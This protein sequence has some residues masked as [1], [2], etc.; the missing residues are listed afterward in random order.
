MSQGSL[1]EAVLTLRA[2]DR[3]LAQ[4]LDNAHRKTAGII[5]GLANVIQTGLGTALGIG[6]A[7]LTQSIVGIGTSIARTGLDF[8]SM[9]QQS[10]I[11][12]TTMLG[13]GEKARSFLDNLQQ[14]AAST[15]FEFPDLV[16]ASQKLVSVGVDASRVIPIMTA[17]GDATAAMGTGGEGIKRATLAM[18]QMAQ[19][20]KVTGEEMLQ[21]VEAGIP[22]WDALASKLGV[23]VSKA[24]DMVSKKQVKFNDLL[25]ALESRSGKAMQRVKGMMD[26]QSRSFSGLLSTL[27]DT[28]AQASG[29][30]MQPFFDLLTKTFQTIVDFTGTED[31]QRWVD[32]AADGV[33][34]FIDTGLLPFLT[35]TWRVLD[36]DVI[37]TLRSVF[38]IVGVLATGD[39]DGGIFGLEEDDPWLTA[40][41]ETRFAL[42]E[43]VNWV[44]RVL[45][46]IQ[47][48][49][50]GLVWQTLISGIQTAW[51]T[52][53]PV[54]A[55]WGSKFWDW[56]TVV[57]LP[58][59]GGKL[60][61]V[62]AGIVGWVKDNGPAKWQELTNWANDFWKWLTGPEGAIQ[63]AEAEVQ[64]VATRLATVLKD[65]WEN[66][67][68]PAFKVWSDGFW[69][70]LDGEDGVIK[71]A[72][73]ELETLTAAIKEWANSA[74][75]QTLVGEL[76]RAIGIGIVEGI[77][78]SFSNTENTDN[79][80]L[81]LLRSFNTSIRN[82]IDSIWALGTT[83]VRGI[84][85]GVIKDAS[86]SDA[87]AIVGGGVY[88][89]ISNA[90]KWFMENGLLGLVKLLAT[91]FIVSLQN[92]LSAFHLTIPI[93]PVLPSILPPL[94]AAAAPATTPPAGL[95][96]PPLGPGP[97][98]IL[99]SI[100][101]TRA[102][103]NTTVQEGKQTVVR[104]YVGNTEF[105]SFIAD[106]ADEQIISTLSAA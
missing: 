25:V 38:N 79:S 28:F 97:S 35:N 20:G 61:M 13:S 74:E 30:V 31:F 16:E 18:Q 9:R 71:R 78:G 34:R 39:F 21:L 76:G 90:I 54:L 80:L 85:Q 40:L 48:G 53:Q 7:G 49:D 46:A 59:L 32:T 33:K 23:D 63:K 60:N 100:E 11:A 10:E 102:N 22:A 88:T 96:P 62:I 68:K 77:K 44:Q 66:T 86:G 8:D 3:P 12:F 81:A 47:S 51:S 72:A 56:L 64:T 75:T 95:T 55:D 93:L 26:A 57:A 1:G 29:K 15:P 2:D 45:A 24:Q 5:G 27:K 73:G 69:E 82:L 103:A 70:W 99:R 98:S 50:W 91:N 92:A 41:F 67:I 58:A 89:L 4:D 65:E 104:V 14:F 94:P 43:I 42:V 84:I 106:I 105:R 19:K 83:L 6:I 17:L 101:A 87:M 37:P 36:N 52:I